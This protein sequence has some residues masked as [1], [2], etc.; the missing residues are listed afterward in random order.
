LSLETAY[1]Q[2]A[3]GYFPEMGAAAIERWIAKH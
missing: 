1:I 3:E 2:Q